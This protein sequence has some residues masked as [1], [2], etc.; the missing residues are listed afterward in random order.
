MGSES[1]Q[2]LV[3]DSRATAALDKLLTRDGFFAAG[4]WADNFLETG[5]SVCHLM[6]VLRRWLE[7]QSETKALTIAA[8]IVFHVGRRS[9]LALLSSHGID[10][11]DQASPLVA[12][13]CY[14]LKR[15]TLN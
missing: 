8:E 9:D 2:V 15:K 14:A 5:V 3:D 4:L 6:G 10:L 11:P 7:D 13:A 12:N 1:P